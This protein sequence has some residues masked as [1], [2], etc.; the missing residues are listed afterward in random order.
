MVDVRISGGAQLEALAQRFK[1]A[2]DS[3]VLTARM[4]QSMRGLQPEVQ[5]AA[6]RG[7]ERLPKRG[8]LARQV[9]RTRIGT[10]V[11]TRGGSLTVRFVAHPNAVA[12]PGAI[13]R[14]RVRHHTF[15]HKPW[16]I[17]IVRSGWFTDPIRA[18]APRIRAKLAKD[19]SDTM[20][21]V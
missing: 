6:E 12:D 2:A 7:A 13:N 15:G 19:L 9:A 10:K 8:G 18:L 20:K 16:E 3:D 1:A 21:K 5:A 17:Q 11:Q 14:G 4:E